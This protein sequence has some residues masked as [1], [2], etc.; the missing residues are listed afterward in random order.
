MTP[1]SR[2]CKSKGPM[3]ELLPDLLKNQ[4]MDNGPEKELKL[5]K[6]LWKG[7]WALAFF[8]DTALFHEL[9]AF[10]T[11]HHTALGADGTA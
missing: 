4:D 1:S 10:K 8:P 5:R 7:K 9:D 2:S 3:F 6:S 11:L